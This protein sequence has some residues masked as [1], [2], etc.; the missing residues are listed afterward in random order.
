MLGDQP[1]VPV[2]DVS[3]TNITQ[4]IKPQIE[5]CI[6]DIGWIKSQN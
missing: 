1:Y 2:K 6:D 3:C 5:K 4:Y